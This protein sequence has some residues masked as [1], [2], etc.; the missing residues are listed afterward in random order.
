VTSW[1]RPKTS[2]WFSLPPSLKEELER[3]NIT[4]ETVMAIQVSGPKR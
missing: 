4:R 1:R 2:V 3:F